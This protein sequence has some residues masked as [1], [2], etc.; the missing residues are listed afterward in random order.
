MNRKEKRIQKSPLQN[1]FLCHEACLAIIKYRM[2]E[3]FKPES[4]AKPIESS[5]CYHS[6]YI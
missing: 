4:L 3:L 1:H 5:S 6:A 2:R